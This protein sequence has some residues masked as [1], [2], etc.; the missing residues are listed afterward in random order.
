ME[1]D[2]NSGAIT[3]RWKASNPKGAAGTSYIIRRR[4]PADPAGQ[5]VFAGVTG[6]KKYT[7][8]DFN[9]GP[10]SVQYTVQGQRSDKAGPLSDIFTVS[11]GR[12]SQGQ[13]TAFV[14]DENQQVRL[15]A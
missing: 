7:D 1:L 13:R 15:A 9:A 8:N 6:V 10:D 4:L 14:T 11:F 2:A 12:N 5:F 3:L